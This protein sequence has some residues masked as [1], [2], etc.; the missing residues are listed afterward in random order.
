MGGSCL[1]SLYA[2]S[3]SSGY[4]SFISQHALANL[5]GVG[6]LVSTPAIHKW[7]ASIRWSKPL[8]HCCCEDPSDSTPNDQRSPLFD[9]GKTPLARQSFLIVDDIGIEFTFFLLYTLQSIHPGAIDTIIVMAYVP[10]VV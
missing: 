5:H 6:H 1:P 2:L 7:K 9:H 3:S 8:D 10:F 4:M